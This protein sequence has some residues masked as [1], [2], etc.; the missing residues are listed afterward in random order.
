MNIWGFINFSFLI[1]VFIIAELISIFSLMININNNIVKLKKNYVIADGISYVF[2]WLFV[3]I[4]NQNKFQY[5]FACLPL[6]IRFSV[7]LKSYCN[8]DE[9]QGE[10][11]LEIFFKVVLFKINK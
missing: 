7:K 3:L 10:N 4:A 8:C 9:Y 2:F 11:D 5:V 6:L 1:I